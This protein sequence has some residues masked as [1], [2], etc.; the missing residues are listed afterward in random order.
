MARQ[1]SQNFFMPYSR[2]QV[3][4]SRFTIPGFRVAGPGTRFLYL[5]N[6]PSLEPRPS[7]QQ[8]DEAKPASSSSSKPQHA[9]KSRRGTKEE[10]KKGNGRRLFGSEIVDSLARNI[11][12]ALNEMF[13]LP[14][15]LV[16]F[17]LSHVF[18]SGRR[19]SPVCGSNT[20]SAQGASGKRGPPCTVRKKGCI[21]SPNN[22]SAPKGMPC[23]A[24]GVLC[25]S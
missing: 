16:S 23:H 19:Q 25:L 12:S 1:A 2:V 10:K 11:Q 22:G 3:P 21:S 17:F 20:S 5:G 4:Y 24:E 15:F 7:T 14:I 9:H 18:L 8:S 13:F 6:N